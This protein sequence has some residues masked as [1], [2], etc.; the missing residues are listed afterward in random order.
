MWFTI[1]L[2][3]WSASTPADLV[4]QLRADLNTSNLL[5]CL[6]GE[7]LRTGQAIRITA[8]QI[9][10][11][12]S[13]VLLVEPIGPCLSG[14]SNGPKW[15]YARSSSGWRRILE[16]AG[17]QPRP[18][19]SKTLDWRDLEL[20]QHSTAFD[21]V[22]LTFHFDGDRYAPAGCVWV[23]YPRESPGNEKARPKE[24]PCAGDWKSAEGGASRL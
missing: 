10:T 1:A 18:L 23:S 19:R 14:A 4:P 22:R 5:S 2:A 20:R 11:K 13:L 24:T 12:R 17:Q 16:V 3:L 7:E 9:A 21:S 8:L 6:D 15:V